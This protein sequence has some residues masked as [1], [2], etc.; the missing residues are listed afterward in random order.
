MDLSDS[1]AE[2]AFRAEVRAWLEAN[3]EPKGKLA[4]LWHSG[5]TH[6]ATE[7]E[8]I[9]AAKV[10]QRKLFTAGWAGITWPVQYGGRAGT[11]IQQMIFNE[12][13]ARFH[14]PANVFAQ[15]IGMAG[16]TLIAHGTESQKQRFLRPMLEG[17]EVW[18]QLFS[19]PG[20][21]SDLASLSTRADRHGDRYLVN[22]QKA[23]TSSAH[24]SD[25]GILLARTNREAPKH[26]GITYFLVDMKSPGIQIQPLRQLNGGAHFNEVFLT[27]VEIPASNVVGDTGDGWRVALSTLTA[28]RTVIAGALDADATFEALRRL[29]GSAP[30]R[31]ARRNLAAA[32][33]SLRITQFLSWRARTALSQGR[34]P[35]TESSLL[36]LAA[37]DQ[38]AFLAEVSMGLLGTNGLLLPDDGDG[39]ELADW[40][41]AFLGQW[42][43]RI[44]GGTA[45]IQRN[46]IA[47]RIL[48]LP[49]DPT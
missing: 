15:G 13:Q 7:A 28:E 46:I 10:W 12:E 20:A 40:G 34:H 36:K 42:A 4:N 2:A 47:E 6:I 23:W 48:G 17:E 22:G 43:R 25:W 24:F 35:G 44:G 14:V 32:Y 21:G 3:A 49:R 37:T 30:E 11:A 1:P 33:V 9:R 31:E 16:P 18:C 26:R 29:A 5:L 38:V 45:E 19:E 8:Q 41:Q 27:D 39:E